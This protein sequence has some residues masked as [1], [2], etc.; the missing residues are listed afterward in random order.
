MAAIN[1]SALILRPNRPFLDWVN[2]LPLKEGEKRY[3]LQQVRDDPTVYLVPD[4]DFISDIER[5]VF[6]E[7]DTFFKDQLV[8]WWTKESDWPQMRT[9][10]MFKD[11]FDMEILSGV[12]DSL[13]DDIEE[14]EWGIGWEADLDESEDPESET[15]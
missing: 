9:L 14:N 5:W 13:E 1:R 8:G 15:K 7:F 4:Y 10:A 6:E 2:S 12:D 3:T 11:W